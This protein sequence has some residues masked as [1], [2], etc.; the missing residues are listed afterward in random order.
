MFG[1][2]RGM[3]LGYGLKIELSGGVWLMIKSL[4]T[5]KGTPLRDDD[6]DF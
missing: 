1:V 3:R 6:D 2:F 4:W 5:L